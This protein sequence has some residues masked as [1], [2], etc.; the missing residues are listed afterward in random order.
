MG[1]TNRQIAKLL[2]FAIFIS[3]AGNIFIAVKSGISL[4]LLSPSL[5][6]PITSLSVADIT[7]A[8]T[9]SNVSI[10]IEPPAAEPEAGP[11]GPSG[12]AGG[13]G[14]ARKSYG[15]PVE[16]PIVKP[17]PPPPS[18]EELVFPRLE[19]PELRFADLALPPN[20]LTDISCLF[21]DPLGSEYGI[22][23]ENIPLSK[24]LVPSGFE[25]VTKPFR[26]NCSGETLDF[27]LNLPN[28]FNN[29]RA[30]R[31]RDSI[32]TE[33][34]IQLSKE[35]LIC[36]GQEI[37]ALRRNEIEALT[38]Y[39]VPEELTAFPET[40]QK[41]EAFEPRI[42]SEGYGVEFYK[43]VIEINI[44]IH[45]LEKILPQ[46]A[47]PSLSVVGSPL[48]IKFE[49]KLS[50]PLPV[51][52]KIPFPALKNIEKESLA[53][54]YYNS[55]EWSYLGGEINYTSS[56]VVVEVQ[57]IFRLLDSKNEAV[58]AVVGIKCTA[59]IASEL[60][61]LYDPGVKDAI[62]LV[63]GFASSPKTWQPFIDEVVL[64]RQPW[65]VWTFAYPFN[66]TIEEIAGEFSGLMEANSAEFES[67]HIVAH[68]LG[69]FVVQE[70]LRDAKDSNLS[71]VGKVKNFILAGS[72]NDGT[73]GID[74]FKNLFRFLLSEKSPYSLFNVNSNILQELS[75]G[76][77][78]SMV[79]DIAY[80]VLAGIKTYE[81]NL[82]FFTLTAE[83]LFGFTLPNDGITTTLGP[84]HVGDAY[85]NNTC[86]DYFEVELTHTELIDH[87]VPRRV[88]ERII[89][90]EKAQDD[91]ERA[92][93][94]YNQ[95][96]RLRVQECSSDDKYIVVG[97]RIKE[98]E[99]V[100][101]LNCACGNGFCGD[102]EDENNC[103]GDCAR[104]VTK[105]NLCLAAKI[106][107]YL[108]LALTLLLT[109]IDLKRY[110]KGGERRAL[111]KII[112]ALIAAS[113]ILL[114][115]QYIACKEILYPAVIITGLV[116]GVEVFTLIK[117]KPGEKSDDGSGKGI[118]GY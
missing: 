84:Q 100:A 105:E 75:R 81:F 98:E 80:N 101:P 85:L 33:V 11:A 96:L 94:G 8:P 104:I 114:I 76:K 35:A 15:P 110:L 23:T 112:Y 56:H 99:A 3:L 2:I 19:R 20:F 90:E 47:N 113:L 60:K 30:L 68:S 79:E 32:C 24:G 88:I 17:L 28:N 34:Q 25:P 1:I 38:Q 43:K 63:H 69:A 109:A 22:S 92:L 61:K 103:P 65:Q 87:P 13:G 97:K 12:G 53:I 71:Y 52:I 5:V 16:T 54:Y 6:F 9:T 10:S 74:I 77:H 72:P 107:I 41:I 82:G 37:S 44:T 118:P 49:K 4:S 102:G 91:K 117:P 67:V 116:I 66:K 95:Y 26:F 93:M 31:C 18:P 89:A 115:Y 21:T 29:L 83:E 73:P 36:G 51:R 48:V 78:V 106:L 57:D 7:G 50:E 111:R 64:N 40:K 70:A 45:S 27:T 55:T 42:A 86:R 46:P 59:C 58:F 39:L 108:L 62:I 14:A